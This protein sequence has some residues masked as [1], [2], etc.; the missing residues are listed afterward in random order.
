MEK[1][2]YI[3]L[4][5]ERTAEARKAFENIVPKGLEFLPRNLLVFARV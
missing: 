1:W 4:S 3:K 5:N 2:A